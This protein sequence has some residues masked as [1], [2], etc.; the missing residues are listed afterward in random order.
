MIRFAFLKDYL[1][2]CVENELA[3]QEWKVVSMLL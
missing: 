3:G 1:G 2:C